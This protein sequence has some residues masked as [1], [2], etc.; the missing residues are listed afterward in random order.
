[1]RGKDDKHGGE[2]RTKLGFSSPERTRRGERRA[3]R[4]VTGWSIARSETVLTARG[5]SL[6]CVERLDGIEDRS[7]EGSG[8]LLASALEG[9][10]HAPSSGSGWSG[11]ENA[12]GG[13]GEGH[14][15]FMCARKG[16][17]ERKTEEGD[18]GQC[19]M[20]TVWEGPD[21][22]PFDTALWA[23]GRAVIGNGEKNPAG[24]RA[25]AP[26]ASACPAGDKHGREGQARDRRPA[27]EP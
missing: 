17:R 10:G 15:V 25:R 27:Q 19:E 14:N 21:G 18:G 2:T 24:G 1:M 16:R 20:K 22:G 4:K 12:A 5:N 23:L 6:Y 9:K 7:R 8:L 11:K 3:G 13:G 26:G